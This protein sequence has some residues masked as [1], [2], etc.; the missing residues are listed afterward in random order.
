MQVV[1]HLLTKFVAC[2]GDYHVLTYEEGQVGDGVVRAPHQEP[3]T[4]EELEILEEKCCEASDKIDEASKQHCGL[5]AEAVKWGLG[6]RVSAVHTR[7]Y[8]SFVIPQRKQPSVLPAQN[9]VCISIGLKS[10]AQTQLLCTSARHVLWPD[11]FHN[12]T[13]I[14]NRQKE[15]IL[16][17]TFF[18]VS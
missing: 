10:S 3:H 13:I 9:T 14:F 4:Q 8:K 5:P 1:A 2:R 15:T 12:N 7:A 16:H 11:T 17:S 6:P 18:N